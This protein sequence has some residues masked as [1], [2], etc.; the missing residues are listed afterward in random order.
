MKKKIICLLIGM[1]MITSSNV[2]FNKNTNIKADVA[3]ENEDYLDFE[4]MW[5]VTTELANVIHNTSIYPPG[6]IKK[7]RSFGSVGD[8]WVAEYLLKEFKDNCSFSNARKVQ[9]G[10]ID[11]PG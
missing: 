10:N 3:E 5:N 4:Y 7:G 1:L 11:G 2:F 8:R 9:L 6:S